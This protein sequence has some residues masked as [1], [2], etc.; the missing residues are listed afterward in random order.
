MILCKNDLNLDKK[1]DR[2]LKV[3]INCFIVYLVFNLNDEIIEF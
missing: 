1:F 3:N 2:V